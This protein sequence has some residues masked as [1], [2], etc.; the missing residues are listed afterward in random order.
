[1]SDTRENNDRMGKDE[2]RTYRDLKVWQRS[3]DE[4]TSVYRVSKSFPADELYGLTSQIHRCAISIPSN[5]A[6]GYGRGTTSD[7][8]R[9]LRI[10]VGSL[11]ELQTQLQIAVNLGYVPQTN[12]EKIDS[13]MR[14]IERVLSALIG[15][16]RRS[17]E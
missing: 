4:V 8:V 14:E 9:F 11:Y 2:I 13:R 16:L 3:M 5:I 17:K 15:K 7:Y 12:V 6:E 10:S 1:M